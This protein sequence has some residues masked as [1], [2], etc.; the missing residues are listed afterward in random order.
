[1]SVAV[2]Q[3]GG[4]R[5]VADCRHNR[6]SLHALNKKARIAPVT[7]PTNLVGQTIGRYRILEHLG[8]G[9]M[10]EVYKA[11]QP[12]LDRHVAIKVMHAFLARDSDFLGRFEREAKSVAALQHP[13]IIQ[14]HDFDV[15]NGMPYMVME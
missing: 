2:L 3:F 12:S 11:Y 14:V 7:D 15:H 10:A 5:R 8:E 1:M 13:N 9:G 4:R 6:A